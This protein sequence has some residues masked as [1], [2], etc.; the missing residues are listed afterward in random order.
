MTQYIGKTWHSS[1]LIRDALEE[2]PAEDVSVIRCD[3]C[4]SH[5]YY[6]DG[7]HCHCEHC[8]RSL[9]HM[10]DDEAGEV[11]TVADLIDA[12]AEDEANP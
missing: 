10:L 3:G 8:G 6:N 4:G 7:S 2:R 5:T 12:E 11:L 9:H 1:P